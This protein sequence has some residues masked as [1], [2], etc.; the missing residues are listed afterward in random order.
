MPAKKILSS[1]IAL[2]LLACGGDGAGPAVDPNTDEFTVSDAAQEELDD[3]ADSGEGAEGSYT[4]DEET[5]V[6]TITLTSSS[7]DCGPVAG[8]VTATVIS[9][10]ETELVVQF[11]GDSTYVTWTRVE[12][13]GSGIIG[14]WQTSDPDLYM[15]LSEDGSAQLFGEEQICQEDRPRNDEQCLLVTASSASIAIDGDL[16][17]WE[18]VDQAATLTDPTGDQVGDD[19]GADGTAMKVAYADGSIFILS[20]F[21]APP[22]T[23]FQNSSAPNGGSYR[24]V[25]QGYNGLSTEATLY[26]APQSESWELSSFSEGAS[27]A[28]GPTGIEWSVDI[29]AHLGEGF[30]GVDFIMVQPIDCSVGSCEYLDSLDCAYF[31]F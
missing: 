5:G 31:E 25:V 3:A 7:F 22:S 16:S 14:I 10:S 20:E 1:L 30:G 29:S 21:A 27:A 9:L 11:E 15:I 26:Y 4:H 28:V 2:C 6:L 18:S 12:S 13:T 8:T 24:L 23:S 19:L 17:D